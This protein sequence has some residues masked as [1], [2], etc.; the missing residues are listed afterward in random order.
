MNVA[1]QEDKDIHLSENAFGFKQWLETK[2]K[3]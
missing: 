2:Y 1:Y 3:W